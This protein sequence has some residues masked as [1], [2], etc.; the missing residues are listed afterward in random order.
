LAGAGLSLW[1]EK[2]LTWSLTASYGA[3]RFVGEPERVGFGLGSITLAVGAPALT[4]GRLQLSGA[5]A[6]RAGFLA[7]EGVNVD[8]SYSVR[9]SYAAA[10]V[11]ARGQLELVPRFFGFVELGALA[12]LTARRFSINE[13]ERVAAETARIAPEIALGLALGL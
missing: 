13:P 8:V 4:F 10:G 2:L 5:L 11:A 1:L 9:R 6:A 3:N 12:P 7:A